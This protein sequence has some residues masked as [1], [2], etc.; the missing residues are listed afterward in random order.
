MPRSR[1]E[2]WNTAY[3]ALKKYR[4]E[5]P[6]EWPLWSYVASDGLRL[7]LWCHNQRWF[8]KRKALMPDRVRKLES[9]GFPWRGVALAASWEMAF[10]ALK[11]FRQSHPN[12]WPSARESG[13]GVNLRQWCRQQREMNKKGK[14]SRDRVRKLESV[15]F[16]W[17]PYHD[18][19]E[20]GF[21]AL[22]L[23]RQGHPDRWPRVIEVLPDE[24]KLGSWCYKQRQRRKQ[25]IV[26]RARITMLDAIGFEWEPEEALWRCGFEALKSFRKL[27]PDGWPSHGYVTPDGLRLGRWCKYKRTNI[28]RGARRRWQLRKF[29]PRDSS[30]A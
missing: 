2:R 26:P 19:W 5:H 25:G 7:G 4:R 18:R 20:K 17:E 23:Y 3:A 24:F 13:G 30:R 16:E 6:G 27:H 22:K 8:R 9:I 1:I 11:L 21:L 28:R 10:A 29:R 15:C 14:L 12:H